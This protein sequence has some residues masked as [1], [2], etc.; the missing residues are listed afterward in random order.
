MIPDAADV[1]VKT[2]TAADLAAVKVEELK[3]EVATL[4]D[5]LAD[6]QNAK[7]IMNDRLATDLEATPHTHTTS[8]NKAFNPLTP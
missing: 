2:N 7:V 6:E 8:H 4:K 1:D 5:K 3:A